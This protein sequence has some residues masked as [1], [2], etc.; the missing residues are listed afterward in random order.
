[1]QDIKIKGEDG[2]YTKKEIL[3]EVLSGFKAPIYTAEQ[4]LV[5]NAFE[6]NLQKHRFIGKRKWIE[7][8]EAKAKYGEYEN[9]EHVKKGYTVVFNEDDGLFYEVKDDE[10]PNLV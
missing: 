9:W 8:D 2:K 10:H 4:I 6:R 3:D 5:S 1:M 7:Y